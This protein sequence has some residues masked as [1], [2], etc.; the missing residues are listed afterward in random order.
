MSALQHPVSVMAAQIA[1]QITDRLRRIE[2]VLDRQLQ[3]S[4]SSRKNFIGA[5]SVTGGGTI[6]TVPAQLLADNL[7]RRGLRVQNLSASGGPNISLGLGTTSPAPN[8][9]VTI[10]PQQAWE[11][12]VS[13]TLWLGNV[14]IVATGAGAV[15]SWIDL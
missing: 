7:N 4:E 15:Y 13:G 10:P 9:G 5:G 1:Q 12:V 3:L 2:H 6:G 8:V 11:G 14:S